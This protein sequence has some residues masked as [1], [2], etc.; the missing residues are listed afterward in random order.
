MKLKRNVFKGY[1]VVHRPEMRAGEAAARQDNQEQ[2]PKSH[3]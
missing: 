1:S 3:H 2:Y